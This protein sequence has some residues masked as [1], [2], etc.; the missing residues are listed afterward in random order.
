MHNLDIK[1]HSTSV[2][3]C[4]CFLA[5]YKLKKWVAQDLFKADQV[6]KAGNETLFK[7]S[8]LELMKPIETK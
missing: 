6:K 2:S 4:A 8:P 1:T 5:K 7:G 3:H